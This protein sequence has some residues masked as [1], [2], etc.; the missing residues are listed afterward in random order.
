MADK[1]LQKREFVRQEAVLPVK[2]RKYTGNAIFNDLFSIGRTLNISSGGMMLT[3]GTPLKV[4]DKLDLELELTEKARVFLI[5][6]VLGG[7]VSE[8]DGVPYRIEKIEF[9]DIDADTEDFIMKHIF[10]SQ[11]RNLRKGRKNP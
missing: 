3:V 2:Y 6:K 7:S 5:G 9:L 10:E 4:G 1:K 8:I 11:R